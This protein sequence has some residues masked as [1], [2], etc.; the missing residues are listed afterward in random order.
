MSI[1]R[2]MNDDCHYLEA[3]C[4]EGHGRGWPKEAARRASFGGRWYRMKQF[5]PPAYVVGLLIAILA[6]AMPGV[7]AP[8]ATMA[9]LLGVLGIIV[10]LLNIADKEVQLFLVAAIALLTSA[11]GLSVVLVNIEAVGSVLNSIL[12]NIMV[13]TA[14]AA[15]VVSLKALYVCSKE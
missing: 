9:L 5:G 13:F 14:P 6:G 12:Y 3:P 10:G 4:S 7:L 15:A 2:Y 1:H 8:A 11:A